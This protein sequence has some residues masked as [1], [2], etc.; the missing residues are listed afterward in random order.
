MRNVSVKCCRKNENT[1]YVHFAEKLAFYEIMWKNIVDPG[2]PQM[3]VW[4]MR[5]ACWIPKAEN[6]HSEYVIVFSRQ[7]L[8]HERASVLCYTYTACLVNSKD[9]WRAAYTNP[10]VGFGISAAV[11]LVSD[12][13]LDGVWCCIAGLLFHGVS[14][15]FGTFIFK[16]Q[17]VEPLNR[18][19]FGKVI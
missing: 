6:L 14:K 7:R 17:V 16:G 10:C 3:T 19:F 12:S 2:R 15:K 5:I 11:L 13:V 18:F 1:F 9:Q 4:R 8:L